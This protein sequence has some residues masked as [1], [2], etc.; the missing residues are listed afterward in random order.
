M[1]HQTKAAWHDLQPVV[2]SD[3]YPLEVLLHTAASLPSDQVHLTL[4]EA[5]GNHVLI[6]AEAKNLTAAFQFFDALKK[7]ADLPGYEWEMA[8]PHSLANDVTQIQI[9]GNHATHD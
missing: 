6:K 2:A 8:Q 7:N 1:V 9:E 3:S 5:E 4:F